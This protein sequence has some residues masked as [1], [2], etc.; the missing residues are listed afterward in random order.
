MTDTA[1]IPFETIHGKG[2]ELVINA[3]TEDFLDISICNLKFRADINKHYSRFIGLAIALIFYGIWF[4]FNNLI[5]NALLTILLLSNVYGML[6][7]VEKGKDF[8]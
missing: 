3:S 4:H 6:H 5:V 7:I 2:V 8:Y 1:K